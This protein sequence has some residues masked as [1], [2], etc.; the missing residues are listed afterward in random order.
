MPA[1]LTTPATSFET[2]RSFLTHVLP[3]EPLSYMAWMVD[4]RVRHKHHVNDLTS[5]TITVRGLSKAGHNTYFAL[6]SFTVAQ[7]LRGD[8]MVACRKQSNVSSIRSLIL[9]IDNKDYGD[10]E[11]TLTAF[12][13]A[14]QQSG[15]PNPSYI[16]DSGGGLHIYWLLETPM[17][18]V[19][20]RLRAARLANLFKQCG[21]KADYGCTVDCARIL[22]APGTLNYK[23]TPAREVRVFSGF[24]GWVDPGALDI[25]LGVG[26]SDNVLAINPEV[27][28]QLALSGDTN[29]ALRTPHN[30]VAVRF[31][32]I[33][34]HCPTAAAILA[35]NGAG[36]PYPLWKNILHLAAY[37]EDGNDYIHPLS[38]GHADYTRDA[39]NEKYQESVRTREDPGQDVGPTTCD[40]FNEDSIECQTCPHFGKIKSPYSL[41]TPTEAERIATSE[42]PTFTRQGST[43][44]NIYKK[45]PDNE[46]AWVLEEVKVAG[47]EMTDFVVARY[48]LLE[49]TTLTFMVAERGHTFT[50][51]ISTAE[52]ADAKSSAMAKTLALRSIMMRDDETKTLR[53]A[54]MAWVNTLRTRAAEG[55]SIHIDTSGYGWCQRGTELVDAFAYAGTVYHPDGRAEEGPAH[56]DMASVYCKSGELD[57]WKKAAASLCQDPRMA[58]HVVLAAS[59]AA[60]LMRYFPDTPSFTLALISSASGV[61]KT[62]ALRVAAAVW[63]EPIHSMRQL[64]DTANAMVKHIAMARDMPAYWDDIRGEKRVDGFLEIMFQLT[65]GREKERLSRTAR[66]TP[67]GTLRTVLTVASNASVLDRLSDRDRGSDASARRVLEFKLVGMKDTRMDQARREVFHG[68]KTSYGH[69]GELVAAWLPQN[70]DKVIAWRDAFLNLLQTQLRANSED[71]FWVDACAAILV[72]A[73]IAK[74]LDLAPFNLEK[75]TRFVISHI[76]Q[77]KI[78]VAEDV[79]LAAEELLAGVMF[80]NQDYVIQVKKPSKVRYQGR[81]N[82]REVER[83]PKGPD[84]WVEISVD[85]QELVISTAAL[86]HYLNHQ[87]G[88]AHT[89]MSLATA[90]GERYNMT[91]ER[92]TLGTGTRYSGGQRWC[93]VLTFATLAEFS[94]IVDLTANAS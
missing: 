90:L 73:T 36:D 81:A 77:Q 60:P 91:R 38:N 75:L 9:D 27:R 71:R 83:A 5:A 35:R 19:E 45:D 69:A 37:T 49:E 29:E 64:N 70:Q 62:T 46:G 17:S 88:T 16:I 53:E 92:R 32:R 22:R 65:Q 84:A 93:R 79:D 8:Y 14:F 66:L 34:E 57:I 68:A 3:P 23:Y 28:A 47:F 78:T 18:A 10:T 40:I 50:A 74:T 26:I 80:A 56:A 24:N 86:Q 2:T 89:A 4:D 12:V 63:A 15:M 76:R 51:S 1:T 43:F 82:V 41:G 85:T 21:L 55:S 31:A 7:I 48:G 72:G 94:E 58:I 61:G 39:T 13:T 42:D 44:R 6:A 54:L 20:H 11:A 87:R 25:A 59:F 67:A 52:L 30:N 33:L